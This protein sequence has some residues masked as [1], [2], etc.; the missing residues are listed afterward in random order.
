M[1]EKVK[2]TKLDIVANS[3]ALV[4]RVQKE[5][6][7]RTYDLKLVQQVFNCNSS[8]ARTL[9]ELARIADAQAEAKPAKTAKA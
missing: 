3:A 4:A 2:R 7:T 8:Q 6:Q 1:A 5:C 9:I